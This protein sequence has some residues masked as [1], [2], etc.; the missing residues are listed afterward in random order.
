[1]VR[2]FHIE[3][4][5]PVFQ[6][7]QI[8]YLKSIHTVCFAYTYNPSVSPKASI[9]KYVALFTF[10]GLLSEVNMLVLTQIV[11][12]ISKVTFLH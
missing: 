12:K 6:S 8:K 7:F 9:R 10:Y 4:M 5:K 1:M 11:K 3:T 2:I